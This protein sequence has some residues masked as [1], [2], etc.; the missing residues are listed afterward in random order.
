MKF[1][2]TFH[3]YCLIWV[4]FSVRDQ[5]AVLLHTHPSY[6]PVLSPPDYILFPKLKMN[7]KGLYF[8]GVAEIHEAVTD[9]L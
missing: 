1:F 2:L 8:A 3:I 5:H 9:E 7:L 4:I 6:S